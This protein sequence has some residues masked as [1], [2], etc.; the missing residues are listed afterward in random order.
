MSVLEKGAVIPRKR[1]TIRGLI[2]PRD[3]RLGGP[4]TVLGRAGMT[5][6]D[7]VSEG[8]RGEF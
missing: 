3:V 7:T 8:D 5:E 1:E 2:R 6:Y 4:C